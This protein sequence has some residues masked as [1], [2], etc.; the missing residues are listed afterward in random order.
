M[1]EKTM[2]HNK[3]FWEGKLSQLVSQLQT[4]SLGLALPLWII[5]AT[6]KAPPN[7]LLY[8]VIIKVVE[9][10]F[11]QYFLCLAIN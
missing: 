1:V 4:F 9:V 6:A 10:Q 5:H 7:V 2:P 8:T 11:H 3:M